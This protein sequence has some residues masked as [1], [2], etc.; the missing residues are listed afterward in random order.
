MGKNTGFMEYDRKSYHYRDIIDRVNDYKEIIV[1]L[2]KNELEIQGSRCMDCGIP[3]CHSLGC[4]INNLIPE[5]ND[6]VYSKDWYTAYK[7]L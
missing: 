1:P 7:R 3:Y 2:S 5:W 4:P 6:L